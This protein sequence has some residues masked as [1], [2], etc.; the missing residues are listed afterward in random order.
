MSKM[1]RKAWWAIAGGLVIISM[2]LAAC[3]PDTVV[4][5]VVVEVEKE[6]PVEVEK[7]VEVVVTATPEP[8]EPAAPGEIADLAEVPDDVL[9]QVCED[10]KQAVEYDD[11]ARTLTFH[12]KEPFAPFMQILTQ[13]WGVPMDM[14]W[15][16]EQG[17]WDG[18]CAN[19]VPYH[20][21]NAEDSVIFDIENGTGPF[22]LEYWKPLDEISAV[23]F[24]DYW[25][26]EP[27]WEGGP[28]GPA[29]YDRVIEK[30]VNEW[31]TRFA[32]FQAGDID[33]NYVPTQ[34]VDQ[35]DP[36]VAE[37][38]DYKTGECTPLNAGGQFRRY[39]DM[40]GTGSVDFFFV[41]DIPQESSYIGSG[42]L[43]G[44]GIPSDFFADPNIRQAFSACF[45]YDTYIAEVEKGE[46][47]ARNGPIIWDMTGHDPED[48]PTPKYDPAACEAYFKMSDLDH[49]GVPAG[50][51][52]DDVWETG[53]YMMLAYN[54]GNDQRRVAAEML[55]AGIEALNEK[56]TIDILAL[57]WPAYLKQYQATY[58]PL[59]RIG[60][61]EDYHHP[62]NWVQPFLS[63]AGAYGTA[64]GLPEDLQNQ[65][66]TMIAEAKS[67]PDPTE[68]H[69]AYKAIQRL[70]NE[71]M[72]SLWGVQPTDR[73]YHPLWLQGY[74]RNT[75][76]DICPFAYGLSESEDSPHP[77]TLIEADIGDPET[78][79]PNY[80][81]DNAT[82][83]WI[84]RFYDPLV[85]MNRE[86]TDEF[87]PNL[88]ESWDI[89]DDG[90]TYTFHLREGVKFHEGGDLD[91]H[92]AAYSVWRGLIQDR[93]YGPFWMYW[94]AI[95][96][97]ET[98]EGYAIDKANA[99]LGLD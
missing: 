8:E 89:S 47:L 98:A 49:D 25:R 66:D 43:D 97:V 9:V 54:L 41:M 75:S 61:G 28:S 24:D 96:G 67:I 81:Y 73:Q 70:A 31:G 7:Q 29:Y 71:Q 17:A 92:D 57:P 87:V 62:H 34:Y 22:K 51:D 56:F 2:L 14:E 4:E 23:R 84:M 82:S 59:Y 76:M 27:M 48:P 77:K 69:E 45:D 80:H 74:F 40:P 19:W 5:T 65:F 86:K 53:F 30:T 10:I 33:W 95:F 72:T 35:I 1:S 6:V 38:C 3:A 15:M 93:T 21:P 11:E 18:D 79:D 94:D 37:D 78:F 32:M 83:C 90:R 85:F 46:A 39:K 99:A 26:T 64:L 20:D 13:G 58:I 91:A 16:V 68:Q 44:G 42:R 60:W 52:E 55:K 50:E 12:L 36:L 88:A 63:S